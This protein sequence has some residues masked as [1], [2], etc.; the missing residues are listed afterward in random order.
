M[1]SVVA[2][3]FA[4]NQRFTAVIAQMLAGLLES[5]SLAGFLPRAQV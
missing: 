1:L 2:G 3:N 4:G 5:Y